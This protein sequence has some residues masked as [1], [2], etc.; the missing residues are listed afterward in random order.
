[1][2]ILWGFVTMIPFLLA[3][4][5][6]YNNNEILRIV[7]DQQGKN[8]RAS[9]QGTQASSSQEK[10][11]SEVSVDPNKSSGISS[12]KSQSAVSLDSIGSSILDFSDPEDYFKY[13]PRKKSS[14]QVKRTRKEIER[15][16]AKGREIYF[17][18]A[19]PCTII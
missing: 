8:R 15:D 12:Q 4:P 9:D 3:T 16:A 13:K 10:T 5:N 11:R 6:E 17:R 2:N 1:M 14:V 7:R 18:Q 19:Q